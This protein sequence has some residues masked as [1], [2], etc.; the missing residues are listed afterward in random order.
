MTFNNNNKTFTLIELLVVIAI[1]GILAAMLLP[2]LT[3]AR[4]VAKKISCTNN[5]KQCGLSMYLYTNDYDSYFPPVHGVNPYTS[6]DAPTKEWW[7]FLQD[8][9]MKR[10]YLICP[11]DPAVKEGFDANWDQRESYIQDS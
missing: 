3:M 8:Y 11:E 9:K 5:L 7:E 2:A 6:P 4:K 1:I 10:K